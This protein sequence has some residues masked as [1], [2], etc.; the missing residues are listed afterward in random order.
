MGIDRTLI[1]TRKSGPSGW[2]YI[3]SPTLI[4]A[5][6][7]FVEFSEEEIGDMEG[8]HVDAES[9]FLG[10]Q[11]PVT[12]WNADKTPEYSSSLMAWQALAQSIAPS[13]TIRYLRLS[14]FVDVTTALAILCHAKSVEHLAVAETLLPDHDSSRPKAISLPRLRRLELTPSEDVLNTDLL[15]T[16]VTS[17]ISTLRS[18][19][20]REQSLGL[21]GTL[22]AH[23]AESNIVHLCLCFGWKYGHDRDTFIRG[24]A[25]IVGACPR[26]VHLQIRG[27]DMFGEVVQLLDACPQPLISL[28]VDA[29]T[30]DDNE[31]GCPPSGIKPLTQWVCDH[32]AFRRLRLLC[33]P[34]QRH[35]LH[36]QLRDVCKARR[37]M[38]ITNQPQLLVALHR[39]DMD[40]RVIRPGDVLPPPWF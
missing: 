35:W 20:L 4:H 8:D 14:D 40:R 13:S 19:Y 10:A 1:W 21:S 39:L 15:A 3:L 32:P 26:L 9:N 25:D 29:E 5:E 37:I 6:L 31:F 36:Q 28:A 12:L 18:L 22:Q 27:N 11:I 34:M 24:M 33:A 2:K 16:I 7:G 30:S 17:N 38:L 23:A